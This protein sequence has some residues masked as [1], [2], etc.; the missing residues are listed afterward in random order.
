MGGMSSN[1]SWLVGNQNK[2]Y[3]CKYETNSGAS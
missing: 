3:G 2:K 1:Y